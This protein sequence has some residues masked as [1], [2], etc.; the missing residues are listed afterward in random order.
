M[1]LAGCQWNRHTRLGES[2]DAAALPIDHESVDPQTTP[3]SF[4]ANVCGLVLWSRRLRSWLHCRVRHSGVQ[5]LADSMTSACG[6]EAI[7]RDQPG[8][9]SCVPVVPCR[10]LVAAG[11]LHGAGPSA[12]RE[13]VA[14][15]PRSMRQLSARQGPIGFFG[16]SSARNCGFRR[17]G[18]SSMPRHV[19]R[20][21]VRTR[22]IAN[23]QLQRGTTLPLVARSILSQRPE[24]THTRCRFH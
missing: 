17:P 2:T 12:D 10:I 16:F 15:R 19:A 24:L 20:A 23:L 21:R 22:E 4:R 8:C 13:A 7:D 18:D 5:E 9:R 1:G 6:G 11:R 3:A 14:A